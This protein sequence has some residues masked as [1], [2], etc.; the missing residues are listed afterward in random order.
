MI[1]HNTSPIRIVLT[2]EDLSKGIYRYVT[3]PSMLFEPTSSSEHNIR[4]N[5]AIAWQRLSD[6]LSKVELQR[7]LFQ[8]S[9]SSP[10]GPSEPL[11]L[12]AH[13]LTKSAFAPSNIFSF[14]WLKGRCNI[15]VSSDGFAFGCFWRKV[16]IRSTE[17]GKTA[18]LVSPSISSFAAFVFPSRTNLA[19]TL[20]FSSFVYGFCRWESLFWIALV[21]LKRPSA[22]W[23]F[24]RFNFLSTWD[25]ISD[26]LDLFEDLF[27]IREGIITKALRQIS[28]SVEFE[29]RSF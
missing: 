3:N 13:F 17:S 9:A 10:E 16:F 22:S 29:E 12:I 2:P 5:N 7:I 24:Q 26:V 15:M 11:V 18:L 1:P 21:S 8:K 27:N 23:F 6:T 28:R 20:A 14:T 25:F 4:A 19:N